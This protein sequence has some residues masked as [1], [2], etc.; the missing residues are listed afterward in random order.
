ML[1][2]RYDIKEKPPQLS[3][4]VSIGPKREL[5]RIGGE[6]HI[7]QQL[8]ALEKWIIPYFPPLCALCC[9]AVSLF[10][11]MHKSCRAVLCVSGR[12]C[13]CVCL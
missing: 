1:T 3:Y 5:I 10:S 7:Q 8:Q 11:S 6:L 4:T 9:S 13:V 2:K 12:V